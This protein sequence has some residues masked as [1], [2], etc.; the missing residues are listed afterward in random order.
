MAWTKQTKVTSVL[1]REEEPHV[2][3][4]FIVNW[5][6]NGTNEDGDVVKAPGRS[7]LSAANVAPEDFVAFEN[8]TEQLVTGWVEQDILDKGI[9]VD[10]LLDKALTK[11]KI[12][13]INKANLPWSDPSAFVS[14]GDYA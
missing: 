13:H 5:E 9:N 4:V 6:I 2:G 11:T 3:V 7:K 14:A 12:N 10:I 8:L 1:T